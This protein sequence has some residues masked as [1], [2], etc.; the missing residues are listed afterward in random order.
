[1]P[2]SRVVH[3]YLQ[4]ITGSL[5]LLLLVMHFWVVHYTAGPV[6]RGELSFQ[7]IRDRISN[8][9]MQAIDI[10]FLLIAL[11]HGLNGLRNI[12]LDFGW[13]NRWAARSFTAALWLLGIAWAYWGI[14]AFS[15]L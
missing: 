12:I 13:V 4:R 2:R 10:A 6:R 14:T 15:N 1:M 8:P 11:Y 7:V 9:W 3:W 5:L